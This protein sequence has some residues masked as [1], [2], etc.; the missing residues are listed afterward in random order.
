MLTKVFLLIAAH[1]GRVV[2]IAYDTSVAFLLQ[3]GRRLLAFVGRDEINRAN[4][5]ILNRQS[6]VGLCSDSCIFRQPC[7]VV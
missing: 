2:V 3:E 1:N 4:P 5:A 7:P 6:V